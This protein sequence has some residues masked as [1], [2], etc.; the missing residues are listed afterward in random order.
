MTL[1]ERISHYRKRLGISQEELGD[2]LG[3]SRQAV[4]KWETGK[5]APDLENLLA[6]A[7]L[8]GVP[9]SELTGTP[10]EETEKSPEPETPPETAETQE[11]PPVRT[12]QRSL[13]RWIVL[14]LVGLAALFLTVGFPYLLLRWNR[15]S[16]S[17]QPVEFSVP[18]EENGPPEVSAQLPE[19][20]PAL[21]EADPTPGLPESN[22]GSAS[23]AE[24]VY[25][26]F[27]QLASDN[28]LTAEE[29][30]ACRRDLF[31]LLPSMDWSEFGRLGTT[32]EESDCIFALMNFLAS[33]E[34]YSDSELYRLQRAS[35]AKGIDGAY[36]EYYASVLS[37]ALLRDP[38]AF[39]RQLA[40]D[41]SSGE[42]WPHYAMASAAYD[43][44][45]FPEKT[46]QVAEILE[47]ALT[48][49]SLSETQS[50]WCRL[51][52]L[53]LEKT[54]DGDQSGLPQTPE[55]MRD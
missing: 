9:L 49:G 18:V 43:L 46:A 32:E 39:V 50:G 37:G 26:A 14:G 38:A 48:D 15:V 5:S 12:R 1:G 23:D 24:V 52:L 45:F 55:E 28:G 16:V 51:L 29:R 17:D 21:P 40:Y 34:D 41:D 19:Q 42:P 25:R 22:S 8:F 2:R 4:S 31:A 53:Y 44:S 7:R 30:Y 27:N 54:E 20:E 47:T 13:R 3:V 11:L 33:L 35:I 10:P 6:L 36:A